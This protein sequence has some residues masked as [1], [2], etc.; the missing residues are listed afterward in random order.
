MMLFPL[1]SLRSRPIHCF[2][3]AS[4]VNLFALSVIPQANR[5]YLLAK[6]LHWDRKRLKIGQSFREEDYLVW[7]GRIYFSHYY[8]DKV[9]MQLR[10]KFGYRPNE[11]KTLFSQELFLSKWTPRGSGGHANNVTQRGDF[12]K[13]WTCQQPYRIEMESVNCICLTCL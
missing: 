7:R 1:P 11:A 5:S 8:W 13:Y 12:R 4:T 2:P 9:S 10:K 3:I 6:I